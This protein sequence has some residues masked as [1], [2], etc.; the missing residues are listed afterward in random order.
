MVSNVDSKIPRCRK[1][2]N[3]VWFFCGNE[4]FK[5]WGVGPEGIERALGNCNHA[6]SLRPRVNM[7]KTHEELLQEEL[8]RARNSANIVEN[9]AGKIQDQASIA[10][11]QASIAQDGT[12]IVQ[13]GANKVQRNVKATQ[14][15]KEQIEIQGEITEHTGDNAKLMAENID[16]TYDSVKKTEKKVNNLR[17]NVVDSLENL[18]S[19]LGGGDPLIIEKDGFDNLNDYREEEVLNNLSQY[20]I[21]GVEYLEKIYLE[22]NDSGVKKFSSM[23]A[24]IDNFKEK[25]NYNILRNSQEEVLYDFIIEKFG[26]SPQGIPKMQKLYSFAERLKANMYNIESFNNIKEGMVES[27]KLVDYLQNA[28][29]EKGTEIAVQKKNILGSVVLDYMINEE[30]GTN[31]GNVYEKLN[32]DNINSMRKIQISNYYTKS[33]KEYIYLLKIVLLIIAIII[34]LLIFNRLEILNKNLTLTIVTILILLG[35]IYCGYRIYL[36]FMRDPIEFDKIKIPDDRQ[37]RELEKEGKTKYKAPL[38]SLG[39]TCVGNDCCDVSMTYDNLRNK[40]VFQENFHNY[41]ENAMKLNKQPHNIINQNNIH[42]NN[43]NFSCLEGNA[44]VIEG[45]SRGSTSD[46]SSSLIISSLKNSSKTK[47]NK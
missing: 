30:D 27:D 22:N 25:N 26:D 7:C 33:Y 11:N 47:F 28:R 4:P 15:G 18:G 13:D 3:S 34:P 29:L 35:S 10:Q 45:F 8:E 31:I 12:T 32:Q 1:Y 21:R 39:I 38:Q 2:A 9:I 20:K 5:K 23:L 41:F 17:D 16:T 19:L 24:M 6:A 42:E 36:L 40:C 37:M 44:N 46:N 14:K 43:K